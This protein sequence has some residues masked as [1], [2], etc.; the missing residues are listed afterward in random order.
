MIFKWKVQFFNSC[1][2]AC[3]ISATTLFR[4]ISIGQRKDKRFPLS[5]IIDKPNQAKSLLKEIV[6]EKLIVL[7]VKEVMTTKFWTFSLTP[8]CTA[9]P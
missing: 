6:V 7:N 4:N 8:R 2:Y 5:S 3:E 9:L 1:F